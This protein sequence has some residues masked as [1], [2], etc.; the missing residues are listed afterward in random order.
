MQNTFFAC[1]ALDNC[2]FVVCFE[3]EQKDASLGSNNG[4]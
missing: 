2:W 3:Q 4:G 1:I